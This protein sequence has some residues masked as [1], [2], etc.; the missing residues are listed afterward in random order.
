V[1]ASPLAKSVIADISPRDIRGSQ[2]IAQWWAVAVEQSWYNHLRI[3]RPIRWVELVS[4]EQIER[5]RFSDQ[6]FQMQ[7]DAH[8]KRGL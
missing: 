2:A 5:S 1:R 4:L 6:P 3:E 7:C 8:A